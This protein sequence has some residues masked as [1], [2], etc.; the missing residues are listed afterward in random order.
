MDTQEWTLRRNCSITPRQLLLV[1]AA[2]CFVS[3]TIAMLFTLRGAWYILGFA[4]VEM[5]AV[6]WAFVLYA[7]HATDRERVELR[8]DC[9]LVELIEVDRTRQ[10]RL[11]PYRT[12]VD[13]PVLPG[14]LV[15]LE[16]SGMRIEVGRFLTGQQRRRFAQELQGALAREV[17][18]Q[19]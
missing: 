13:M 5:S 6:A 4:I 3:L 17:R 14:D 2:L 12:R 9:L 15:G 11:N 8:S 16:A 7:R 1:Y 18:Q 19:F 10:F